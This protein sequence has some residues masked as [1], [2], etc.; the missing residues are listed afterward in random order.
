MTGARAALLSVGWCLML[1][2]ALPVTGGAIEQIALPR[3]ESMPRRPEPFHL[4]D[5]RATALGFDKLAFDLDARGEHLPLTRL[6]RDRKGRVITFAMPPYVGETRGSDNF[7]GT[8]FEGITCLGAVWGATL[9]GIDKSAGTID[10]VRCCKYYFDRRPQ[11]RIIG[12]HRTAEPAESFWYTLFPTIVYGAI[13]DRYPQRPDVAELYGRASQRWG[14]AIEAMRDPDGQVNFD[15]TGF[16]FDTMKPA[17]NGK[18]TEPDSAGALAW[19]QFMAHRMSQD[20]RT[21][22][23]V[24]ACLDSLQSRSRERNPSYEVLMPFGV[25]AASRMNAEHGTDY[26]V[27]KFLNWCFDRSVARPD[28]AVIASRWEGVD[29]HGLVGAVNRAPW[30]PRDGGYAFAMNTFV[31]AWPLVPVVRYDQRF[32]RSIGRWML[33]AASAARLFYANSHPRERQTCPDWSGDP[34]HVVAYEGLKHFWDGDEQLLAS[35]DPLKLKWGPRTDF[36]LYGS[37]YAGVFGAI[38]GRTDDPYILALDL[39]ATDT[40]VGESYPTYLLYNP[41][42][43]TTEVTFDVG[44]ARCDLYDTVGGAF[45]A[46]GASGSTRI[47]IEPDAAVVLVLT[48][49]AATITR[50]DRR[51]LA[52]GVVIDYRSG[53]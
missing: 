20:P 6:V 16:D 30:K 21:L 38:V 44:P 3:V 31:T 23:A 26:D 33:N 22:S 8:A 14:E 41:H 15:H 46:R 9:V 19:I 52:N 40:A 51:T 27:E 37:A 48:P 45:I 32:A 28:F 34:G 10:Y 29:V 5:W 53:T 47:S 7:A 17:D 42:A 13:A 12:N 2:A 35:G 4:R 11:R 39:R 36:G 1:L 50:T 18:W 24:R 49:A 43:K 25:L